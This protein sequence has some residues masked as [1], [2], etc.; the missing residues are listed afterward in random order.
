MFLMINSPDF[1]I[2]KPS[3]GPST[4]IE[5]SGVL[6]TV[7]ITGLSDATTRTSSSL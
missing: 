6:K 1:F 5:F 7:F 2:T 3:P 4:S